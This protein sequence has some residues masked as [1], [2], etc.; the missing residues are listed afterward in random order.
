MDKT[1]AKYKNAVTSSGN[2]RSGIGIGIATLVVCIVA[3]VGFSGY[4]AF[5]YF[6]AEAELAS[7][8]AQIEQLRPVEEVYNV[9]V[10]YNSAKEN[11][12]ILNGYSTN[13]NA[14]IP[15]F[16][17]ELEDKMPSSLLLLSAS[18]DNFGVN[19]MINTATMA[20]AAVVLSELRKFETIQQL[21]VSAIAEETN[22]LGVTTTAFSVTCLYDLPEEPAALEEVPLEEGEALLEDEELLT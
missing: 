15:A 7:L 16:L 9:Y 3:S 13:H 6:S 18:C 22:E 12:E 10:A 11:I 5:N 14:G 8:N 17:E 2:A 19:M 1:S 20:D 4:A 21:T